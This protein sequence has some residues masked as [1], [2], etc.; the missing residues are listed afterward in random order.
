MTAATIPTSVALPSHYTGITRDHAR[1]FAAALING[2]RLNAAEKAALL[3]AP[4]HFATMRDV[5]G[6]ILTRRGE[7]IPTAGW[8]APTEVTYQPEMCVNT[9]VRAA[10]WISAL[11][12]SVAKRG[13]RVMTG[14][15]G[16]AVFGTVKR[17]NDDGTVRIE[18]DADQA[19][20]A[21]Y[22]AGVYNGRT[23]TNVDVSMCAVLAA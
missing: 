18:L 1:A 19:S 9:M 11:R 5:H 15:M 6:V 4:T 7:V 8:T 23:L 21:K 12:G 10:C 17:T 22:T 13:S 16:R 2:M 20:F 3:H 14:C